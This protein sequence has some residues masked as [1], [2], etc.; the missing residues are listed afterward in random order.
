VLTLYTISQ[1]TNFIF[2]ELLSG[3]KK[4]PSTIVKELFEKGGK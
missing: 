3:H 4:S 2:M 1:L